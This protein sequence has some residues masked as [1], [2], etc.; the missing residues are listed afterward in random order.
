MGS[1]T[2]IYLGQFWEGCPLGR[3]RLSIIID[4]EPQG[5]SVPASIYRHRA[6]G[7]FIN[8]SILAAKVFGHMRHGM[9]YR[10]ADDGCQEVELLLQVCSV[11]QFICKAARIL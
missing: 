6:Y 2:Q 5:P 10:W 8:S 9:R 11:M 1:K 4:N 3:V 7:T